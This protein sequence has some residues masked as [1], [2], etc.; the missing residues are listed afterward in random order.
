M[1]F[2][3]VQ[4]VPRFEDLKDMAE[5]LV[6]EVVN[7]HFSRYVVLIRFQIQLN[8]MALFFSGDNNRRLILLRGI[9]SSF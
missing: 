8:Q 6:M 1:L 5:A 3:Q 9:S 2:F 4:V 7:Q